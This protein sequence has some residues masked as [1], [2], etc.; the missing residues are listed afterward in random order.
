MSKQ[1]NLI[2]VNFESINTAI[3][4]ASLDWQV[5]FI[6]DKDT[7]NGV[8]THYH[9]DRQL[10]LLWQLYTADDKICIKSDIDNH[11]FY[12]LFFDDVSQIATCDLIIK[13][14]SQVLLSGAKPIGFFDEFANTLTTNWVYYVPF[15]FLKDGNNFNKFF[16]IE[17]LLIGEKTKDST[18]QSPLL[19]ILSKNS[20]KQYI[21]NIKTVEFARASTMAMLATRLSFINEMARLADGLGINIKEVEAMMGA[22]KRIGEHYLKAGWGFGGKSLP[23]ELTHLMQAFRHNGVDTSLLKAVSD[24]NSDQK[25]W[26]FRKFWQYFDGDIENKEVV[27]WGAGYRTGTPRTTG[28]AIHSLLEL[29]WAYGIKT[30]IYTVNTA[31]ELTHL[32]QDQ[33]LFHTTDK[34]YKLATANALFVINWSDN[35]VIDIDRLNEFALPIFDA[36]NVFD[37]KSVLAYKGDYTGVGK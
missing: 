27:I 23:N 25:E 29:F 13:P 31:D 11:E 3:F 28:S 32:Y 7:I 30:T 5:N 26:I 16:N 9:F 20:Q 14:N 34:P 18:G 33:S 19:N 36:K 2:G 15:N 17:L 4:L 22:D 12:W 37:D 1:I 24:V 6:A 10:S 35:E 21:A 8:L